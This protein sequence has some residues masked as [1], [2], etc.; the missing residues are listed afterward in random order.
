MPAN[1][2]VIRLPWRLYRHYPADFSRWREAAVGFKGW[3]TS[4]RPVSR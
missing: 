1:K 4:P 3:E 2:T